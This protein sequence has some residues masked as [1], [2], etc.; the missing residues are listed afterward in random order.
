[1]TP[2]HYFRIWLASARYAMARTLMYRWDFFLWAAVEFTWMMV[3]LLL[4]EVLYQHTSSI[5]GWS[6]YEMLLLVGTS[7]IIQRRMWRRSTPCL[8]R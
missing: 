6:K 5:A 1:M 4:V 3:N 2:G 7:M 8:S